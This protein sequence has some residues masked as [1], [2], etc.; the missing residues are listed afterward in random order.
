MRGVLEEISQKTLAHMVLVTV[1][2]V[3]LIARVVWA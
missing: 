3:E 1:W 2:K